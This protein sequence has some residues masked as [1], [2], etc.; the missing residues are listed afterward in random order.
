MSLGSGGRKPSWSATCRSLPCQK[1]T[2]TAS[3]QL[4]FA[5]HGLCRIAVNVRRQEQKF[6]R[7]L[8]YI[9]GPTPDER[10]VAD[11]KRLVWDRL[12]KLGKER[13][14][15][16]NG[17]GEGAEVFAHDEG[18]EPLGGRGVEDLAVVA[19]GLGLALVRGIGLGD[20]VAHAGEDGD[21]GCAERVDRLLGIADDE[22]FVA[23]HLPV[24]RRQRADDFP[25]QG[26]GVLEFVDQREAIV[27]GQA[28]ADVRVGGDELL[29]FL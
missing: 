14:D 1:V 17:L 25:L 11:L 16:G 28:V 19:K 21:I 12:H 10:V 9:G 5:P 6:D 20:G 27:L 26:I 13:V 2:Q 22:E 29:A 3:D 7:T 18:A 24:R 8:A 15:K 4:G 23:G